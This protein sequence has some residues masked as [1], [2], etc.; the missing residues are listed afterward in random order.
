VNDGHI[1]MDAK[2][3]ARIKIAFE[4]NGGIIDSSPELDRH[5]D[6]RGSEAAAFSEDTIIVKSGQI[7]SASAMFEELI[8]TTQYKSGRATGSNWIQMEIEAKEKLVRYQKQYKIPNIENERTLRQI[9]QLKKLS[10]KEGG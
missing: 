9:E 8:H 2:Q 4:K 7:P 3:F 1:P 6:S 5:L 10:K